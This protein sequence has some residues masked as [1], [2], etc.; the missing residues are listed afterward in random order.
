MRT[1]FTYHTAANGLGWRVVPSGLTVRSDP[2]LLEQMIRNLLSNAVKYTTKGKILLGCRRR[3][4]KL[5]IEVWDTGTAFPRASFRRSSRSSISSTIRRANA[6]RVSASVSPS[7]SAW[8]TCW[9][10]RSMSAP[11]RARARSSPSRCRSDE[12]GSW[13]PR[14]STQSETPESAPSARHDPGRRGRSGGARDARSCCSTARVTARRSPRMGTRRWSLAAQGATRAGSRRRR[15]QSAEGSQRA[16]GRRRP[17]EAAQRAIPAIILTGDISTDSLA[18]DRPA[19]AA[20][21]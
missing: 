8:P 19:T 11:V 10:T 13:P 2:R 7:C 14:R 17:A 15:L 6:A 18:R 4:D 12:R 20:C 16:R 21:I 9:A 5:R 3:G 1:E